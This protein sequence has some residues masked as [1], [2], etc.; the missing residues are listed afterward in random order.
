MPT[1]T[2]FL[3]KNPVLEKKESLCQKHPILHKDTLFLPTIPNYCQKMPNY[4]QK[5]PNSCQKITNCYQKIPNSWQE[6]PNSLYPIF[7][8][9]TQFFA[10]I[11]RS[12]TI[13]PISRH[14]V[15][16]YCKKKTI[17]AKNTIQLP[18]IPYLC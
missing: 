5:I 16:N 2:I 18:K 3:A 17:F 4:G 11:D 12:C 15:P 10:K 1:N 13:T 8:K 14:K 9:N 6:L 7:A